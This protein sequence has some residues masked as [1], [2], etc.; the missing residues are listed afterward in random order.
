MDKLWA[1][2]LIGRIIHFTH[3]VCLAD[4]PTSPSDPETLDWFISF[5]SNDLFALSGGLEVLDG[6]EPEAILVGPRVGIDYASPEHV[7]AP[8][9]FAIAGTP[10]ISAPKNT[11]RPR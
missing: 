10:W 8:W 4:L 6:P 2:P 9:R 1:Y 7:A 3:L 5:T 11:L